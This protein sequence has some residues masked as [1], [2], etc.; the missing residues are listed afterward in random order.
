VQDVF[1][2]GNAAGHAK[3]VRGKGI[4][5]SAFYGLKCGELIRQVL[6]EDKSLAMVKKDYTNYIKNEAPIYSMLLGLQEF[7]SVA[8][9][10]IQT[11]VAAAMANQAA[12]FFWDE[13]Y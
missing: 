13:M 12:S 8:P 11:F 9:S 5:R 4:L 6:E 2:A 1:A 3:P 7:L 10:S